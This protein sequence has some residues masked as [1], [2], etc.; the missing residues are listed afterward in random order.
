MVLKEKQRIA[1]GIWID[2]N[3]NP[4]ISIHELLD[5][6]GWPHDAEHE[7]GARRCIDQLIREAGMTPI[8]TVTC[9][10]C[11]ATGTDHSAVCALGGK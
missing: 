5:L 8:H 9:P 10:N 4:H 2:E 1:P 3:D 11:G 7:A 6:F